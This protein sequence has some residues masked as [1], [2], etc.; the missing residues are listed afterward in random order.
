MSTL[1]Q[2]L[3]HLHMS[4]FHVVTREKRGAALGSYLHHCYCSHGF[5]H[6][7]SSPMA[8]WLLTRPFLL[9]FD[10]DW[11]W[12]LDLVLPPIWT[13]FTADFSSAVYVSRL[14]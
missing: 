6:L 12:D 10:G 14:C 5:G 8:M 7:R 4:H 3:E 11:D 13:L 2:R 9:Y 1:T